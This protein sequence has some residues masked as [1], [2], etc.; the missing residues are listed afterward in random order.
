MRKRK[1][2]INAGGIAANPYPWAVA[3]GLGGILFFYIFYVALA[4]MPVI[5]ALVGGVLGL[6]PFFWASVQRQ[7]EDE[8]RFVQSLHCLNALVGVFASPLVTWRRVR[9]FVAQTDWPD[10]IKDSIDLLCVRPDAEIVGNLLQTRELWRSAQIAFAHPEQ[11]GAV[12][13]GLAN[14]LAM[15]VERWGS[16]TQ[17]SV[18]SVLAALANFMIPATVGYGLV[19]AVLGFLRAWMR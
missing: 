13:A 14:V 3:L 1:I 9:E 15:V 12:S 4:Q 18:L 16:E 6:L 19:V 5:T 7:A 2:E 10:W 8:D 17:E 11:V